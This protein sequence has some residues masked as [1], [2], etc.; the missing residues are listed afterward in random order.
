[1]EFKR[2][3]NSTISAS[4]ACVR[5]SAD[6]SAANA[7]G[8]IPA[9]MPKAMPVANMHVSIV[10]LLCFIIKPL[11]FY[12]NDYALISISLLFTPLAVCNIQVGV[13]FCIVIEPFGKFSTFRIVCFLVRVFSRL[14]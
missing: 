3:V 13:C 5:T 14:C 8:A 1:M 11:P 2:S 10:L 7:V 6:V 4:K 12:I 9:V